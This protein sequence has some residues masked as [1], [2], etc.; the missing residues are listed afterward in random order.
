MIE[1]E[2][3][4]TSKTSAL[5]LEKPCKHETYQG[6]RVKRGLFKSSNGKV[7]N[8]DV[9]GSLQ[10][11][12]KYFPEAFTVEGIVSCAVQPLLV[13]PV[14]TTK[15]RFSTVRVCTVNCFLNTLAKR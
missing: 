14:R 4:Y 1:T 13:N 10:I 9:N 15:Q 7:I 6:K 11:I 5:D 8:A 12:R 3:S 2:E